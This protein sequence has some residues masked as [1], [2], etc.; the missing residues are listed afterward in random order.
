[1]SYLI[2]PTLPGVAWDVIKRPVWA[3]KIQRVAS[4]KELRA[5]LWSYPKYEF[6][7]TYEILRDDANDEINKLI[8]FFHQ[9]K[10]SLE[11]FYFDS[12]TDNHITG[13]QLGIGDGL[14][15]EFYFSLT[16]GSFTE[17]LNYQ[18][19]VHMNPPPPHLGYGEGGYGEERWG[20]GFLREVPYIYLDG[21]TQ[22]TG[23]EIVD[24]GVGVKVVFDTP[25]GEGVVIT[26]DF[27]Y[28]YLV[29]FKDD[30]AEFNN[31]AYKLW[32][33]QTLELIS[34]KT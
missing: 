16:K 21:V 15:T 32:E 25:P 18:S 9:R 7:L 34:V 6:E 5:S 14:E 1:M 27:Y 10:G 8:G 4:G 3:T 24:D 26:T 33:L 29:R 20:E 30:L 19:C 31:F 13:E 28:S 22:Y 2:L 11:A 17:Q 23:Y 12:P